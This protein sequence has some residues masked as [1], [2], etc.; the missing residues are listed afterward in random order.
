[1]V[2]PH[3]IVHKVADHHIHQF[4]CFMEPAQQFQQFQQHLGIHPV[5]AVHHFE[6]KPRSQ[7]QALHHGAPMARVLLVDRP[8]D[9]RIGCFQFVCNGGSIVL[10]TVI[11]NQDLDLISAR[12]QRLYT[13]AHIVLGI[14]TR[15]C[16]RK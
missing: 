1:M 10:G 13:M 8:D 5:V 16:H 15:H 7:R 11:H 12:D 14:V 6:I 2:R 4:P 3:F 9:P